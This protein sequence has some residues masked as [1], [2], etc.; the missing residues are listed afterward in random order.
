MVYQW[1]NSEENLCGKSKFS[2][3]FSIGRAG[4]AQIHRIYLQKLRLSGLNG[5]HFISLHVRSWLTRG[6]RQRENTIGEYP[7]L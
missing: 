3:S 2:S 7:L 5:W 4:L 1:N 6:E